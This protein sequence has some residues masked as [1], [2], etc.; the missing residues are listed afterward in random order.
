MAMFSCVLF[1]SGTYGYTSFSSKIKYDE[2]YD[3]I[4]M[5]VAKATTRTREILYIQAKIPVDEPGPEA[6]YLLKLSSSKDLRKM[7]RAYTNI[8]CL[9]IEI[10]VKFKDEVSS[11]TDE[12]S[13]S[14]NVDE[15]AILQR[16]KNRRHQKEQLIEELNLTSDVSTNYEDTETDDS[17]TT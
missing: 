12:V 1:F 16:I 9:Y 7:F 17:S 3:L 2:F 11:F 8:P 5:E 15:E 4:S 13:S 10:Y 6:H 14:S